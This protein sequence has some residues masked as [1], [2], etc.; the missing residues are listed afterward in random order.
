[1]KR[2]L[3]TVLACRVESSSQ[4]EL[5]PAVSF[6]LD[7]RAYVRERDEPSRD[8]ERFEPHLVAWLFIVKPEAIG[9]GPDLN[10]P[11]PMRNPAC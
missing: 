3:P 8:F 7:K 9:T 5:W 6:V 4:P 10:Y 1:M 11:A 2:R